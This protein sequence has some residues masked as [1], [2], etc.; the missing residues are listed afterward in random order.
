VFQGFP[1]WSLL[2]KRTG[3]LRGALKLVIKQFSYQLFCEVLPYCA[4]TII[5]ALWLL[6]KHFWQAEVPDGT[7]K[8]TGLDGLRATIPPKQS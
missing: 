1:D 2:C 7:E 3:C 8:N 6:G 5:H 4:E